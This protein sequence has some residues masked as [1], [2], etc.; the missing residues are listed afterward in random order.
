VTLVGF[1]VA[2]LSATIVLKGEG[3]ARGS[4]FV[5]KYVGYLCS[6]FRLIALCLVA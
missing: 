5:A 6:R 4:T 3:N 2:S 1:L